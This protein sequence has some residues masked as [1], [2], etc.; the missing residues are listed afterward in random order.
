MHDHIS[1]ATYLLSQQLDSIHV[2]V[3][4][5]EEGAGLGFSLA[6]GADLEN[7]TVT[8]SGPGRDPG[9]VTAR[10]EGT[11]AGSEG[12]RAAGYWGSVGCQG[13]GTVIHVT[14]DSAHITILREQ[15]RSLGTQNDF[16]E[17]DQSLWA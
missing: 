2:T 16:T 3:L 10:Q 12:C 8:V 17:N 7:K 6:G 4:H 15:G 13:T 14:P 1:Y 11:C 5:K 9:R